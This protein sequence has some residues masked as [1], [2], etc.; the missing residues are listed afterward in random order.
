MLDEFT[1]CR[2][3]KA[4]FRLPTLTLLLSQT[5]LLFFSATQVRCSFLGVGIDTAVVFRASHVPCRGKLF[6]LCELF[7]REEECWCAEPTYIGQ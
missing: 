6:R 7:R 3:L 4:D 5:L 2:G 1:K